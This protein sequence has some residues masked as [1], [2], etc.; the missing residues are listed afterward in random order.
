MRRLLAFLFLATSTL[1]AQSL[2]TI[3]VLAQSPADT[4]TDLQVVCLFQPTSGGALQGALAKLDTKTH[5]LL[6]D[7]RPTQPSQPI[8]F[9]ADTSAKRWSSRRR[10]AHSAPST[11]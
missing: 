3:D 8:R 9:H 4:V 11:F 5:G 2:P 7:L 6:S 10:P 1:A